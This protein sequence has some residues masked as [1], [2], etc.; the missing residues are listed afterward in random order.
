MPVKTLNQNNLDRI[1]MAYNTVYTQ[2]KKD[3]NYCAKKTKGKNH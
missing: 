1:K 3:E 2:F